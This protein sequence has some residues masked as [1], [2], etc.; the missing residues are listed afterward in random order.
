MAEDDLPLLDPGKQARILVRRFGRE[1]LDVRQGRAM[2]VE[3]LL[4]LGQGG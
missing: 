1:A 4:T 3:R 2:A